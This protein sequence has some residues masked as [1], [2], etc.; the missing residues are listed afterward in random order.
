MEIRFRRRHTCAI[1]NGGEAYCWGSNNANKTSPDENV[2]SIYSVPH[3]IGTDADWTAIA[4]GESHTCGIRQNAAGNELYC[5][6]D[7]KTATATTPKHIPNYNGSTLVSAGAQHTCVISTDQLVK[8]EQ[9]LLCFGSNASKQFSPDIDA[10]DANHG[11]G[12]TTVSAST[13]YTCAIKDKN[14]QCWGKIPSGPNEIKNVTALAVTAG[15]NHTCI[16]DPN[17]QALCWGSNNVGQT[18]TGDIPVFGQT[19]VAWPY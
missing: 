15:D 1:R 18:G 19:P 17:H 3:R 11:A 4:A 2:H 16:I 5:W 14:L 9:T 8:L 7:Y 13:K 6:G 10:P 12:W